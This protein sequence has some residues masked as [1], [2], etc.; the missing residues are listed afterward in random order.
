MPRINGT[1]LHQQRRRSGVTMQHLADLD[2][3]SRHSVYEVAWGHYG[4]KPELLRKWC[5]L[6][7]CEPA[8]IAEPEGVIT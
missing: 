5:E 8:D 7:G 2:G 1:R 4:I 3:R 6:I